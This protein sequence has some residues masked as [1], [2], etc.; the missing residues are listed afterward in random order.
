MQVTTV[1]RDYS[2]VRYFPRD[3]GGACDYAFMGAYAWLARGDVPR[4]ICAAIGLWR[5]LDAAG[6]TI[7]AVVP[8]AEVK[9]ALRGN[10]LPSLDANPGSGIL[11]AVLARRARKTV[12]DL[13]QC[14]LEWAGYGSPAGQPRLGDILCTRGEAGPDVG[15]YLGEDDTAYHVLGA[16]GDDRIGVT[17]V[18]RNTLHA[19]RR[20]LYEGVQ[21]AAN[22]IRLNRDGTRAV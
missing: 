11:L 21:F 3:K 10:L 16:T 13:P 15:I 6:A 20:P 8:D 14:A 12:P 18:A 1:A 4:M 22:G 19:V 5:D 2:Y 9:A 7:G 17:R